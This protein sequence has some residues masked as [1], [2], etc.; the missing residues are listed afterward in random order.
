MNQHHREIS[1]GNYGIYAESGN[2]NINHGNQPI[3]K[4]LTAPPFISKVFIG[5]EAEIKAVR[6][7]LQNGHLLLLVNGE[8]GIGKTTLAAHY[9]QQYAHDYQHLAWVFAESSLLDALLSLA[10]PLQL[11]F[12]P[13]WSSQQRLNALLAGMANLASPCLLVIDNANNLAELNDYYLALSSCPN[14]HILLTTR[15]TEF[16]QAARYAISPL[17]VEL[18]TQL[19]V[20]HYP[21]HQRAEN[22]LLHS[23]LAAVGY[24]TLVIELLAKNLAISNR[25]KT[26]YRLAELLADLQQKG[27]LAIQSAITTLRWNA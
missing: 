26:R 3:P 17:P 6:Q 2:I 22:P 13:E 7:Q 15:I 16:E 18:A 1:Q 9:Y 4:N 5:R 20:E 27:L 24:N 21:Q 25:L 23:I 8:G 11:E 10:R 14:F 12:A 19:F